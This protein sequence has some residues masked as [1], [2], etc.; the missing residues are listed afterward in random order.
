M[1]SIVC[2]RP[3]GGVAAE[4]SGAD[5]VDR[6][7]RARAEQLLTLALRCYRPFK[8]DVVPKGFIM[9]VAQM[10]TTAVKGVAFASKDCERK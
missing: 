6:E 2:R 5:A 3:F 1:R 8:D 4:R 9:Y 7:R 10:D